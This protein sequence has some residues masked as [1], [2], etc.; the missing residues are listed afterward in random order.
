LAIEPNSVDALIGSA[1]ADF[2]EAIYSEN[3][4]R[5]ARFA[6]AEASLLK[7]QSAAPDNAMAHMWLSFVKI[8]SNRAAQG[9]A[10]AERSLALNRN[11]LGL[12][13]LWALPS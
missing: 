6:S 8:N 2:W 11:C 1:R 4:G 3:P 7:A 13:W 12:W 5:A 9:F 10:D